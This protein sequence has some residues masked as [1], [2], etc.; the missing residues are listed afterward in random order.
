MIEGELTASYQYDPFGVLSSK[1]SWETGS[2]TS[3]L[4]A[5]EQL[6]P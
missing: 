3:F 6:D 4:F 5:G 2:T 1:S